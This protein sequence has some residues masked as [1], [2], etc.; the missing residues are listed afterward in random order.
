MPAMSPLSETGL[1]IWRTIPLLLEHTRNV[2]KISKKSLI[3]SHL[4]DANVS[5]LHFRSVRA[6]NM[7]NN[8]ETLRQLT[9]IWGLPQHLVDSASNALPRRYDDSPA[10][11]FLLIK[12]FVSDRELCQDPILVW[13]GCRAVESFE[14]LCALARNEVNSFLSL[15]F[16][17]CK[18]ALK[19]K[20]YSQNLPNKI[21]LFMSSLDRTMPANISQV[22]LEAW[23]A[24]WM[25]T[26]RRFSERLQSSSTT[27]IL[28][29]D[30]GCTIFCSWL[31]SLQFIE[32][33]RP[34]LAS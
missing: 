16:M 34:D 29:M 2:Q 28:N 18:S 6:W 9:F 24:I 12:G 19:K 32:F 33:H 7:E 22:S 23:H 4:W 20:T 11:V 1:A 26:E 13:P 27:T 25:M 30:E 31:G 14:T 21:S 5:S 15:F 10:D 8:G 17:S 3:R